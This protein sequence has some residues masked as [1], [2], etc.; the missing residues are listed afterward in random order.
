MN[1]L[2]IAGTLALVAIIGTAIIKQDHGVGSTDHFS[3]LKIWMFE[4]KFVSLPSHLKTIEPMEVHRELRT[5]CNTE[6]SKS[7]Q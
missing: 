6:T 2:I 4:N 3:A 5:M 7:D 1:T